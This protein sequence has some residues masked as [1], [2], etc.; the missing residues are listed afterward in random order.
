MNLKLGE[1]QKNFEELQNEISSRKNQLDNDVQNWNDTIRCLDAENKRY[2]FILKKYVPEE[3]QKRILGYIDYQSEDKT[4]SINRKKAIRNN[5]KDNMN[6][7]SQMR[8]KKL[9]FGIN[10]SISNDDLPIELGLIEQQSVT[11]ATFGESG[12][13][14]FVDEINHIIKD[15]DSDLSYYDKALKIST[16]T[17]NAAIVGVNPKKAL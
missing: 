6:K 13:E 12:M 9:G 11:K 8:K 10:K 5:Y 2:E 17:L 16:P 15:D 1:I 3:E 7:L 4:F 14:S